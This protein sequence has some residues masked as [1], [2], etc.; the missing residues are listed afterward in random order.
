MQRS[1]V[2]SAFVA[3]LSV[4]T[5]M[6]NAA[7][8]YFVP[9]ITPPYKHIDRPQSSPGSDPSFH[10]IGSDTAKALHSASKIQSSGADHNAKSVHAKKGPPNAKSRSHDVNVAMNV[11]MDSIKPF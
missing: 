9:D 5:T 8:V 3:L 4:L 2:L 1:T 7:P 6:T 11:A 10:S